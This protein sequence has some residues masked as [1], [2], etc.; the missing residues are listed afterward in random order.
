MTPTLTRTRRSPL[1]AGVLAMMF[2]LTTQAAPAPAAQGP[3]ALVTNVGTQGIQALGG[4][5]AERLAR[6]SELFQADFDI[7]GIGLFALGRYRTM[8]TPQETQEFFRVYPA[9]TVRAFNS[10][11][12][13]YR[14]A[15]FRVTGKRKIGGGVTVISSEITPNGGRVQLDWHL[16]KSGPAREYRITDVTIGGV[17]MKIALRDQFASWIQS[18]GGRFDALLAVMRQQIAET[19]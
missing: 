7:P 17:S 3:A 18:N 9:F 5:T 2:I 14:G 12:D 8:A 6:L 10:R 1:A 11:L 13:E 19:R 15:P 16:I 4:N